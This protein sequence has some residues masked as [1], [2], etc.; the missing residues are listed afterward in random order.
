MCHVSVRP[1]MFVPLGVRSTYYFVTIA[2]GTVSFHSST[3]LVDSSMWNLVE[4]CLLN[5]STDSMVVFLL[6]RLNLTFFVCRCASQQLF[7][8]VF[9]DKIAQFETQKF[10]SHENSLHTKVSHHQCTQLN[11][12]VWFDLYEL[13]TRTWTNG[14]VVF[15]RFPFPAN[16]SGFSA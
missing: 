16:E 11:C 14:F 7:C 1:S 12:A 10:S 4:D 3:G 13:F 6:S 15:V 2:K 5:V 9:L 8:V